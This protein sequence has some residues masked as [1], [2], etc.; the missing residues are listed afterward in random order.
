[1]AD[2]KITVAPTP[3]PAGESLQTFKN[4]IGSDQVHAE[5]VVLVN[6]EG[7]PILSAG[8][9]RIADTN[10]NPIISEFPSGFLN[11]KIQNLV[12]IVSID[13]TG[14]PISEDAAWQLGDYGIPAMAVRKATPTNLSDTDGDYEMLQMDG[15]RLHTRN[16]DI[17]AQTD[18]SASSDTGTFSLISLFKRLLEKVTSLTSLFP[19]SLG[20]KTAANSFSVTTAT[21][22]PELTLI[23]S[24]TES[25]PATDTASSGLN[26]RLQR[27]AQRITSLIA[28]FP[29]KGAA[30]VSVLR[31]TAS[32]SAATL[33]IARATRTGI[34]IRNLDT[35]I[36]IYVGPATVTSGNGF[37][38]L[39]GESCPFSWVGL[40]QV[41]AASGT[42]AY[43]AFDEYN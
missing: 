9:I 34:L 38:I 5:A 17:G 33:A 39:P 15:G 40:I 10:G 20:G 12:K 25:V 31:A 3:V 32:T 41:I 43:A 28:L 26:G 1:M 29:L 13:Q 30:N 23:G 4:L 16:L 24:L 2:S 42:P 6:E 11:V 14:N 21:D 18:S 36:T 7:V 19:A 8:A 37:P 35:A 27:I 22:D